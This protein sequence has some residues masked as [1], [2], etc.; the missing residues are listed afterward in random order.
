MFDPRTCSPAER[1]IYLAGVRKG[2][3]HAQNFPETASRDLE[4]AE[5]EL[6]FAI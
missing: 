2:M 6:Q 4:I 3:L 1:A 5:L